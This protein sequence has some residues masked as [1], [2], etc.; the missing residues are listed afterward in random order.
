MTLVSLR[1]HVLFL[2][3]QLVF[4]VFLWYI[5]C[6]VSQKEHVGAP[7]TPTFS[8]EH[9]SV[10]NIPTVS[11]GIHV[12]SSIH[13]KVAEL[14]K[15]YT[16]ESMTTE[17]RSSFESANKEANRIYDQNIWGNVGGDASGAGSTWEASFATRT[18]LTSLFE[19]IPV[20]T[21][22]DFS[23]G[24]FTWMGRF[25]AD[26][27]EDRVQGLRSDRI[28]HVQYIGFDISDHMIEKHRATFKNVKRF[29]F[30]TADLFSAPVPAVDLIMVR[31]AFFHV[32]YETMK[33]SLK[34]IS[35]SGSKWLL[36]STYNSKTNT[37]V[38]S[39]IYYLGR[40]INLEIA[41]FNLGPPIMRFP[42]S[43]PLAHYMALWKLPLNGY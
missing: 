36:T 31:E 43:N 1:S 20:H 12:Y 15:R 24:S 29:S 37:D 25:L 26:K 41:P 6:G 23:C 2:M 19:I 38:P 27:D 11:T 34:K 18:A 4:I 21:M 30:Y 32:P 40:Y 33:R 16:I 35:Q 28:K 13:V 10:G 7:N 39:K 17:E 14:M 9:V 22:V 8:T 5:V 42:E 3:I